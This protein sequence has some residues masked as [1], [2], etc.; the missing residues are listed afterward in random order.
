[1]CLHTLSD[2][3]DLPGMVAT[4]SRYERLSTD[5]SDSCLSFAAPVGVLLSC[6]HIYNQYLFID[7]HTENLKQ[8]EKQARNMHSLSRY[9]RANQLNKKWIEE[10][11]NEAHSQGLTS[12]RCHCNVMA[13]SDNRAELKHIKNDRIFLVLCPLPC[14]SSSNKISP[15][16]KILFSPGVLYIHTHLII[17][18]QS[19]SLFAYQIGIVKKLQFTIHFLIFYIFM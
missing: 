4:D 14:V 7:N 15:P 12:I 8:F 5:R 10:Y 6:N 1:M 3:E 13:W 19:Q 9:S 16:L 2:V 18:I 17:E 11:L